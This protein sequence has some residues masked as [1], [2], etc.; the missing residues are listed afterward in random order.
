MADRKLWNKLKDRAQDLLQDYKVP[1]RTWK[2]YWELFDLELLQDQFIA[3][4]SK[5]MK[6]KS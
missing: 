2:V 3:Q 5:E 6:K 4:L 1:Q